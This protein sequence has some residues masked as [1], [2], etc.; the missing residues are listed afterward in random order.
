MKS[1]LVLSLL[2]LVSSNVVAQ[3]ATEDSIR[4]IQ[5]KYTEAWLQGN[6]DEVVGLFET[7]A[8]ISPN[9][10]TAIKGI[11]AIRAFWFPKDSSVTKIND[12]K[13]E[14][15]SVTIDGATA[16]TSQKTFLSW[17]YSKRDVQISKDQWGYAMTVYRRQADGEWKIWR[18]LWTDV[19]SINK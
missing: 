16:F 8:S 19:K 5:K 7:S 12:F 11:E 15:V 14:I 17:T 13:N 9:G 18:Q 3:K 4:S 1:F 6:E 2:V 10:N